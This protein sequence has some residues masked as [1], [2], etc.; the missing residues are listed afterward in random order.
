MDTLATRQRQIVEYLTHSYDGPVPGTTICREL[1]YSETNTYLHLKTLVKRGFLVKCKPAG[2]QIANRKL[3]V[4]TAREMSQWVRDNEATDP[5]AAAEVDMIAA[6]R[7]LRRGKLH[8][9]AELPHSWQPRI[10]DNEGG[11]GL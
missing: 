3:T 2:Y 6:R 10:H 4:D 9:L 11:V 8:L 7:L 5:N 1:G